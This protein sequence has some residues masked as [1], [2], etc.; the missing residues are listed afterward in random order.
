MN[1]KASRDK[2][3]IVDVAACG[4]GILGKP[5]EGRSTLS[6]NRSIYH[7]D[8]VLFCCFFFLQVHIHMQGQE[9]LFSENIPL[10]EVIVYFTK[11]LSAGTSTEENMGTPSWTPQDTSLET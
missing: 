2:G 1:F 6:L 9:A 10:R 5:H 7:S 4:S 8:E 11:Q 3:R